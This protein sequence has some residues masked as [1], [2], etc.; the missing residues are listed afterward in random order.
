MALN[1]QI[2]LYSLDTSCFYNDREMMIHRC[3]SKQYHL[4][5][6]ITQRRIK[7]SKSDNKIF[8]SRMNNYIS[9]SN[10]RIKYIK[11]K[12]YEEFA[13]N[14]GIRNLNQ[15]AL[16]KYNIISMFD[17]TLTRIMKIKKDTIT[18]DIIVVQT[19]FFEIIEDIILDG[20]M[21]GNE[22][23][24]CLTASAGQ[25]RTKKTV[26]I[27]EKVLQEHLNTITC[28]LSIEKINSRGGVNINKYLAYLALCNSATD[29]WEDFDIR[30]TI[31]VE[32]MET[33]VE[34]L[35]D[36]IDDKTYEIKRQLM[37][38]PISHTD[39]CG[40]ILK[41]KKSKMARAPWI[42]GLL[43][44][45]PFDKFIREK[46]KETGNYCGI[47]KDI[48][49]KEHDILKEKIE[50]I[51]T[52]SQFK[53]WKY[54]DS[55]EEYQD[56]FVKYHCQAGKCNEEED[57]FSDAK[58]NYQMLQTLTDMTDIELK[59]ICKRTKHSI[60]KIG[61]DRKT[62]LKVLGV[63]DSNINKNYIQQALEIYPE[64]LNDTYSKEILKQVKKS[65]VKSARSGKLDTN[66]V[67]TFIC[68]DLYAFCEYLFLGDMNP[69]GLLKDKEVYCDIYKDSP[70][71]DCL[72]S[73][74]LYLEHAIRNNVVDKEKG[75]WFITSGLYTSCHDIIS[76]VLMFDVDGDKSLVCS[77]KTTISVAE[78][79][80]EGIV[81][82]YYNMAKAE[83]VIITN[84][85]IYEGLK[86]AYTGGN[87]GL[88]SNNI[89]KIWNSGN[90]NLEAIK[91]LCMENN[92]TI[93]YAKTLYKPVRPSDKQKLITTYTKSK[94]PNFFI[95]AK[96]KEKNKVE[97]INNSTV[98]RLQKMIPNPR[99]DFK[100]ANLGK[101]NYKR[102]MHDNK[103]KLDENIIM[104]YTELDLRKRFMIAFT[105]NDD[106]NEDALYLYK[107]IREQLLKINSDAIYVT[108]VLIKFLYVQKKSNHKTTL[109][110]SFGDIIVQNLK[111]NV[112]DKLDDGNIQCEIC[113]KRVEDTG[114]TKKYCS[115]C[116]K[117]H[118]REYKTLKQREYRKC[119]VDTLK[120]L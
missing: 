72:R 54:Y 18:E 7:V 29:L 83:A 31:V 12:L 21:Y 67:Y 4:R 118:R 59:T 60:T 116:W 10:K 61:K 44:P 51:F 62:M 6:D 114:K 41:S 26:F 32:D 111:D 66:G 63:V 24:V 58:L 70:K 92:F 22:K 45:N 30:K 102:L 75:R 47:I 94:V 85:S 38:I 8:E 119:S 11:E 1:S 28:G 52:K 99:I 65:M 15:V 104:K 103:V 2:F 43:V 37:Q 46:S 76:K 34:G 14:V 74:H 107:D 108:D 33:M 82:L 20:F 19:Y 79:N 120:L 112:K 55:W 9:I 25:I 3:L 106:S 5:A 64:L 48:Y 96:D 35:V 81:P 100:A 95:Y 78:R 69:V 86:A 84:R 16:N 105:E 56:N 71:L 101:F 88:F 36:L 90:I 110:S 97:S 98:N 113:G 13:K 17:S 73:P 23:Y 49:G 117:K 68:P 27:K 42:K 53:M 93:D 89:T 77:E 50:V 91:L 80:M 109:W 39:G 115:E 40:M 57:I 87:I